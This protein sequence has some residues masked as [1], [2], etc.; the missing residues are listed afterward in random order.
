MAR[1]LVVVFVHG[2][3]VRNTDTYG[4]LPSQIIAEANALGW[5]IDKRHIFLGRYISFQ[6]EVSIPDVVIALDA[7]LSREGL[8]GKRFCAITHSTGAPVMR[9]WL[10]YWQNGHANEAICP[11]SHLIMLAPA[12][13][14]SAL[15]TLGR[16]K[17]GR[18]KAWVEG[19]VE[20]GEAVL[21]WLELGN[22]SAWDLN[23][24]WINGQGV[25]LSE[26]GCFQFVLTGQSIDRALYDAINSY[27]GEIG[28]D[29]VVRVA[30]ANLNATYVRLVQ[31]PGPDGKPEP[32]VA[33]LVTRAP[34]TAFRL[35]AGRSHSGTK[36]GILRSVPEA[37]TAAP[38]HP[39]VDAVMRCLRVESE[40][41]YAA[42]CD[43]FEQHTAEVA[44]RERVEKTTIGPFEREFI[45]SSRTMV[46]FRV[47]DSRGD[48]IE[49][50]DLTLLGPDAD[51]RLD[52]DNL[53]P[54]FFVDRQ[55]NTHHPGVVT[56]FLD[57]E[58][59]SRVSRLGLRVTP[60]PN[61]GFAHYKEAQFEEGSDQLIRA[62]RP[63]ATTL[64]D[65]RLRRVVRA[66]TFLLGA[67]FATQDFTH[68]IPSDEL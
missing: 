43:A 30:A 14:G 65:I 1:K 34:R 18:L 49:D 45:H 12:N 46:V 61:S 21:D 50:F 22:P 20:P 7:A 67:G 24:Q 6:D 16:S 51:N 33:E 66:N 48:P 54:G 53:P 52:P 4:G 5:A 26:N 2:W 25:S 60:R 38:V 19:G 3:S 31:E 59:M 13:F 35:V 36:M 11:L 63:S 47:R 44:A 40:A 57:H 56:Y 41:D 15:A 68:E 29:G 55:T 42:A 64:V 39:T 37:S 17:L 32:L 10:A 9:E 8:N 27:T 23:A 58:I 28:S 62:L